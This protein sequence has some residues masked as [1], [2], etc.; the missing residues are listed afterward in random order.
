MNPNSNEGDFVYGVAASLRTVWAWAGTPD[1][2]TSA[3]VRLDKGID[4]RRGH[5]LHRRVAVAGCSPR[6]RAVSIR[7]SGVLRQIERSIAPVATA[8]LVSPAT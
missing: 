3:Y 7:R 1:V 6:V 4:A 5:R 8:S 2:V